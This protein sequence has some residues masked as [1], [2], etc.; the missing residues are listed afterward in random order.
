MKVMVI[1]MQTKLNLIKPG[2]EVLY[3]IQ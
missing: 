3:T 1:N 2:S